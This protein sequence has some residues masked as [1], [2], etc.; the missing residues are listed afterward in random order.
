M[1]FPERVVGCLLLS[2]AVQ[3]DA[4]AQAYFSGA[5]LDA[6]NQPIPGATI[7]AGHMASYFGSLTL[8]G[9]ASTDMQGRYAITTLGAGDGSGNY[10]LVARAPGRITIV[11]PNTP[12]YAAV[13]P[14]P[15][16]P[17][18]VAVPNSA[19]DFY[20][21][22]PASVSGHIRRTDTNGNVAN[23]P[24]TVGGQSSPFITTTTDAAGNYFVGNLLPDSYLVETGYG[25]AP[26]QYALLPQVY[27]GHD[28]DVVTGVTG[29][30]VAISDG[31]NVTGVDFALDL[32]GAIQGNVVSAIDSEALATQIG[33]QR[34][35]PVSSGTGFLLVA[36]T[37]GYS[38]QAINPPQPGQYIIQPLLPG[39]LKIAFSFGGSVY[40]PNY[41]ADAT[42]PDQAQALTVTG[43][44]TTNGVDAHLMPLQ[45]I[46]G[47]ITDAASGDPVPNV[48]V[49]GGTPLPGFGELLDFAQSLTD[50]SGRYLLQGLAP[51]SN[52]VWIYYKPGYLDQVYPNARGCCFAP[53]GSQTLSLATG[54]KMTAIDMS[55]TRGAYATGLIRDADTGAPPPSAAVIVYDSNGNQVLFT[56]VDQEGLFKTDTLP[57]GDYYFS[58]FF[59]PYQIYYPD[60]L[61]ASST[62]CDLS[63]AQRLTL[64]NPQHYIVDFSIPHLDEIF[65]GGF[66]P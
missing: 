66:E 60:Y 53:P 22:H 19:V 16:F 4:G 18:T 3:I 34:L 26:D 37:A 42:T 62:I 44:T 45:T 27:A 20:L 35:T 41:Y 32:G 21:F 1:I 48:V 61:C 55:I 23:L 13:C 51:G 29:D 64:S 7:Q 8:D 47:T 5:V 30:L 63:N 6:N 38:S 54:Q 15:G 58:A 52:Y 11:Y 49:H 2:A 46:A 10:V 43:T 50:A 57:T 24:V 9:Q 28:F 25:Q 14:A 33:I 31:A 59:G 40:L 56:A 17:P 39:T 65:G 36:S 12:C